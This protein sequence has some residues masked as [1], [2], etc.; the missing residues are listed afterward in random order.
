MNKRTPVWRYFSPDAATTPVCGFTM[1]THN[2]AAKQKGNVI[3]SRCKQL[4]S[5]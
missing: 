1:V 5:L 2:L 3:Y 4:L